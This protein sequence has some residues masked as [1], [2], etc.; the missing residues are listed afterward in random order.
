MIE[1]DFNKYMPTMKTLDNYYE[2][3]SSLFP[4]SME[5]QEIEIFSQQNPLVI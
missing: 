5:N 4:I 3:L 2:V 1:I